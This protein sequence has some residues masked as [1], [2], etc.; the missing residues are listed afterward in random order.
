MVSC[1]VSVHKDDSQNKHQIS[2]LRRV[3]WILEH[4]MWLG[5]LVRPLLLHLQR[6]PHVVSARGL[7]GPRASGRRRYW[8]DA[9]RRLTLEGQPGSALQRAARAAR[10]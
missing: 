6:G 1:S 5:R 8:S 10:Q 2:T 9:C 7:C 3:A 4:D